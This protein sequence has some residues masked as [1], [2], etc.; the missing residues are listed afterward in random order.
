MQFYHVRHLSVRQLLRKF[1]GLLSSIDNDVDK[2][3]METVCVLTQALPH[4]AICPPCPLYCID[5]C[6]H[7]RGLHACL[8]VAIECLQNMI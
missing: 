3:L 2:Q 8:P 5:S 6:M 7:Q 1:F 4:K